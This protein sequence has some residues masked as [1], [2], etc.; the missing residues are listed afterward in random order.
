MKSL[1]D[2]CVF[3]IIF[4]SNL[5][6]LSSCNS[7]SSNGNTTVSNLQSQYMQI[8]NQSIHYF[9]TNNIQDTPILLL[10]GVGTTSSFWNK[11]FIN[12]LALSHQVFLL[13]YPGIKST[14]APGESATVEYF[15]KITNDF[16]TIKGIRNPS[17]IGWSMGGS[18]ALQASFLNSSLYNHLYLLSAYV[19]IGQNISNPFPPHPPF[20]NSDDIMNYV[21]NNN[22]YDYTTNQ[23][24]FY[25]NQLISTKI[26]DI[27]PS[28]KYTE[29]QM[30]NTIIW[31]NTQ[32][33]INNFKQ[34]TT[35]ATFIIPDNDTIINESEAQ[36]GIN[37]YGGAKEIINVVN[38]GHDSSLQHPEEVCNYIK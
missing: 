6:I 26:A 25:S 19:P 3:S 12:C 32:N 7:S 36:V 18:V 38:S 8:G 29:E 28:S 35:P 22:L 10:T 24:N 17:L 4:I 16:V 20:K 23:L 34:S 2:K 21:Y 9:Q 5:L 13:D 1:R 37:N 31:G 27:F 11:N 15:A 33:A 14:I 30:S